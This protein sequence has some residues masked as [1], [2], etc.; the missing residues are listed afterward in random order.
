LPARSSLANP[1]AILTFEKFESE[2]GQGRF[3]PT[4]LL[5][6]PEAYLIRR[7]ISLFKESAVLPE[8]R[9]FNIAEFSGQGE[10]AAE[11][12][13]Q[14]NTF[15]MMS[16]RRLVLVTEVSKLPEADLALLA[17]YART[18]QEKTVLVLVDDELDR[19]S[20]FYRS[21]AEYACLI[22]CTKMKGAALERWTEALLAR[23]GRRISP[24][25]CKK[26]L[27]LAGSDMIS[28]ANE[29]EKLILYAGQEKTI[30]E[31]ALDELV[32]ASRLHGIFALTAALG[33][34]DGKGALHVL[35]NLLESGEEPLGILAM[36]ARHF[37][38]V[39]IAQDLLKEG[40][41][42]AE[43]GR[44]IQLPEFVLMEFLR[45]VR[46]LDPDIARTMY[47]RL[48]RADRSF[49]STN[50]DERMVLEHLI[51]SL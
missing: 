40:R 6:G 50:A 8:A 15:P 18:P 14:A 26:L 49:K 34:R 41:P 7:A 39:L 23:R 51:C 47:R 22:E 46:G 11:I 1:L 44:L 25:A 29:V 5:F 10:D 45:Q 43:I 31:A 19:R 38:Q 37:R 48:A 20:R 28:L 32:Q 30:P 9:A 2:A 33:K 21:I 12:L 4:Y 3:R 36:M 35:G 17:E 13:K 42:P 16:P 27:D 24:A